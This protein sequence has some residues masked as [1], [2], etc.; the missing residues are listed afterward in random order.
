MKTNLLN[1]YK[2]VYF[3]GIGGIGMSALARYFNS[4]GLKVLGYD[5]T[6]TELTK[7]LE[8]EGCIVHYDDLG[9]EV[10]DE[11]T[12]F[13]STLFI[14]TP[15]IPA[16]LEEFK[17]LKTKGVE[18]FKRS[19]ILGMLTRTSKGLCV[20]GTHGKTTTSSMLAHILDQSTWGCN[21]FLGG[22][23][24]NFN[25]NLVLS[26]TSNWTVIEADEF[27]RS[28]L[29]LSPF[30]S[31]ITAADPDHLDIYGNADQFLDGFRQYAM[32]TDLSGVL[33]EKE[34]LELNTLSKKMTYSLNSTTA[35]YSMSNLVWENNFLYGDVRLKNE[36]WYKVKLGIPGLHNAEN[37]LGCIALLN[38]L[39]MSEHEIRNGLESFLGVKRRFEFHLRTNDLIYIDDY[40][41]HPMEIKSLVES[42]RMLYPD[43]NVT[44]IFQPHLF[45]RTKDF[46]DGFVEE[47][48]KLDELIL[49]PIY[50]A[51][52]EPI[53]GISSDWLLSKLSLKN[54]S[55]KS[56]S[57]VLQHFSNYSEGVVLTIGAGDIDR[58]VKPLKEIL[59]SNSSN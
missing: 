14:Y 48:N 24:T 46:A 30:A 13:S 43:K 2:T 42:I 56:P 22:I 1:T 20:A 47:L 21:A 4:Q 36:F 15:A 50:P 32:K 40:A 18:L 16:K 23:A 51:R 31:I 27:D 8:S 5:K 10:A 6:Q 39:G 34:G 58:I 12:D 49:M 9:E 37:A 7:L 28:F 59:T 52:E 57:E 41:H 17:F 19:E 44:G 25:S 29:Q 54:K 33:V 55:L 26:P 3:L 11:I 38:E 35:D 53:H 45:S